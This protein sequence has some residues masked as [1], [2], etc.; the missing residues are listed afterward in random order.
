MSARGLGF[1]RHHPA[2]C[3]PS[4]VGQAWHVLRHV[5]V[6]TTAGQLEPRRRLDEPVDTPSWHS[7]AWSA[8]ALCFDHA[9]FQY[10]HVGAFD[11]PGVR[12]ASSC[13]REGEGRS[14]VALFRCQMGHEM[15]QAMQTKTADT[16]VLEFCAPEICALEFC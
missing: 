5:R 1:L 2:R 4:G 13:L 16:T 9:L 15:R 7:R 12:S 14:T 11:L 3:L 8:A 10:M 6:S